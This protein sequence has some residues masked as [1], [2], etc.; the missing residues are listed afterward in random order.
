MVRCAA[1][2]VGCPALMVGCPALVMG[3][4]A[5]PTSVLPRATA[6]P[7]NP[8]QGNRRATVGCGLCGGGSA[9]PAQ[10]MSNGTQ[11]HPTVC[12]C[13]DHFRNSAVQLPE[14]SC[15]VQTVAASVQ[16]S[17]WWCNSRLLHKGQWGGHRRADIQ[18]PPPSQGRMG[19][20]K[21]CSAISPQPAA[22]R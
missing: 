6:H 18:Q 8:A 12:V 1:L 9:T 11:R 5:P 3:C 16:P 22:S 19:A 4:P 17:M 21:T 10:S 7:R 2:M 20:D 15:S 13:V 14:N